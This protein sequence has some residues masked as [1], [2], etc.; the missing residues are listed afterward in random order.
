M[1][2]LA[3][4]EPSR[5]EPRLCQEP[6]RS[7]GFQGLGRDFLGTKVRVAL[8]TFPFCDRYNQDVDAPAGIQQV[9]SDLSAARLLAL[10]PFS[11]LD[12]SEG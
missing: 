1:T 3:Y 8:A 6:E 5:R 2:R 10:G 11:R 12:S 4:D 9:F 7:H